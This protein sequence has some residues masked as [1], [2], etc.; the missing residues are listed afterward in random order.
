V[1]GARRV[2]VIIA[3]ALNLEFAATGLAQHPTSE[4]VEALTALR[5]APVG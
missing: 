4:L 2:L 3:L 5:K 1:T